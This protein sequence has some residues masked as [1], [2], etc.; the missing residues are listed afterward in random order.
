[1]PRRL[2]GQE[3]FRFGAEAGR[4]SCLEELR[5]LIEWSVIERL[6]D[7]I[8][9]AAKG[10]PAWPPLAL[11]KALLIAVWHDLSDVKLSEALEDRASFRRFCGFSTTETTPERTAFVRF[12]KQLLA[13]GLD[14]ELFNEVTRQLKAKA[15]KVKTGTL[16][17][18]TVIASA[19]RQDSEAAGLDTEAARRSTA[20]RRMWAP[21]P[22]Q[23][24]SKNSQSHLA[25]FMTVVLD[26]APCR[27]IPV[28]STP[29]AATAVRSSPQ[30]CWPRVV[31]RRSCRPGLGGGQVT[32]RCA[33]SVAGIIACSASVAELRRS[34]EPGNAVMA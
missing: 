22:R 27:T 16:V 33:R 20:S 8:H 12:R 28:T 3:V 15:V 9:C 25:T 23:L 19:S 17:D 6:L 26:I 34:L 7:P 29:I 11:F 31:P 5:A 24:S 10:E 32:I 4:R 1:M 14:K 2:I 18:A 13:C 21:T 30:R